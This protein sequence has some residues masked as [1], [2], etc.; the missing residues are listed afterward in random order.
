MLVVMESMEEAA[1]SCAY[2][3]ELLSK[4]A[5]HLPKAAASLNSATSACSDES[6]DE[7]ATRDHPRDMQLQPARTDLPHDTKQALRGEGNGPEHADRWCLRPHRAGGR[8]PPP[9]TAPAQGFEE[10]K[11]RGQWGTQPDPMVCCT[12]GHWGTTVAASSART[13]T[14]THT[15]TWGSMVAG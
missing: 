6:K 9:C 14:H 11:G 5:W 15:H 12:S 4:M 10:G 1:R 7:H 3:D 8:A 2:G 13:H